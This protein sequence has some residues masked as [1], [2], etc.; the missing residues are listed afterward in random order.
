MCRWKGNLRLKCGAVCAHTQAWGGRT[1]K[2]KM[3]ECGSR[4]MEIEKT[5]S[6]TSL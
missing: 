1:A 2:L 5:A 6:L 4:L 3:K